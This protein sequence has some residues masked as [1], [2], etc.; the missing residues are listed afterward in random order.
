[1][2]DTTFQASTAVTAAETAPPTGARRELEGARRRVFL[3]LEGQATDG[4][5][6]AVTLSL[7]A[8]IV[9]NMVA[10]VLETLPVVGEQYAA[11]FA[12][13]EALSVGVFTLEY[14]LR[15]WSCGALK[16][17]R[18]PGGRLRFALTPLALVDLAV[19]LPAFLPWHLL[20]DFR[21]ARVLR[22][23]R[24]LRLLKIARY[25]QAVRLFGQVLA[26]KRG[27]LGFIGLL[28]GL[29]VV[30]ASSTMYFVEHQAQPKVFSSIPAAMWWSIQTLTT[31]GYGDIYPITPAGRLL[32][33]VIALVGIGFFALPAGVLAA[34]YAQEIQKG[35]RRR[36]CCPHCGKD[37]S[38][39]GE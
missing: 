33:T 23:V 5:A 21:F 17:Y 14:A 37:L 20:F 3:I 22:L 9:V 36:R 7:T 18:G 24:I 15:L 27:D 26:A 32:G 25:S 2:G 28:L 6:R 4:V 34:A 31:V 1:M 38:E 12:S 39:A 8:L 35:H 13:F 10:V 29:I 16:R 19:V 30:L 11:A